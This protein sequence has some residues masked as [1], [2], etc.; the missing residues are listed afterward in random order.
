MKEDQEL[1]YI[2]KFCNKSFPCGRSLGGHMRS[3]LIN[4]S[5]DQTKKKLPFIESSSPIADYGLRENPKKTSKFAESSEDTNLVPNQN[6]VCKECGKSFQ[7][8]KSLFGHMK[9]HS[10]KIISSMNSTVEED[11]W[12]NNANYAIQNQVMDIQSDTET[13]TPNKKKRSSRKFKRYIT[14]TTSST[15]TEIEQEQEEVAMSLIILSRDSRNGVGL[16]LFTDENGSKNSKCK[17]GEL[18]K[19]KKVKNGKPEKNERSK[20][21]ARTLRISRNGY[22]M[23]KSEESDDKKKKIKEDKENGF[24]ESEIEV[25]YKLA[26]GSYSKKRNIEMNECDISVDSNTKKLRDQD[27]DSEKK[28]KF[29]C[30]ACNKSFHSYQAL[31]GHRASHKRTKGCENIID[32]IEHMQNLAAD[33]KITNTKNSSNDSTIETSSVSKKLKGYECPICFKIFQSGQA[34]GGHKRSHLIAEAKSNNQAVIL[35]KPTP[36]I[37]DFLDLNLPAPVEE[38]SNEHVGFQTWW[39]GSS[40]KHEQLVGLISN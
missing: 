8:W 5:I 12:N 4:S 40:H 6:K 31:G 24:E 3:H 23:D 27:S 21:D 32:E 9:C 10:E 13:A 25:H 16:N 38:E 1:K 20:S 36:E 19:L 2:C 30:T 26:K 39:I 18:V 37:R 14:T 35:Q 33:N 22:N 34:L 11:P 15:V 17:D 28:I 29:E 7:S